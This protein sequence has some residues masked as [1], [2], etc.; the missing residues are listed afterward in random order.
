MVRILWAHVLLLPVFSVARGDGVAS[1]VAAVGVVAVPGVVA[2]LAGAGR[3][4]RSVAVVFGLLSASA[5]LVHAWD[6]QIEGHFH[7]FVMIAVLALYEDWVPFGLAIVYVVV[8]HGVLGA[9][10]PQSVYSHGGNPW[11]WAG[12]HGLF[13]LGSVAAGVVTWRLNED[14]RGRMIQASD[15]ACETAEQFRL[16]FESGTSGMALSAPDGRFMKV[17]RALC[18]MVGYS[19]AKMLQRGFQS[20]THPD[21]LLL[22][23]GQQRA[24]LDGTTEVYETEKRY[25]HCDGHEVWVRLGVSAVREKDGSVSYFIAQMVDVTERRRVEAELSHRALHDSLTH[26]PNRALFMDRLA[27]ALQRLRREPG[28]LGVLFVDLDRFKL[29]NDGMGHSAGDAILVAAAKRL[30][31]ATRAGDTVARFGGDEYTVLCEN[32]G[33]EEAS[34]VAQRII[35]AFQVPFEYEGREFNLSASIGVCVTGAPSPAPPDNL[36]RDADAAL[37]A[38]KEAGRGHHQLFDPQRQLASTDRLAVEHAI[39]LGLRRGEFVLH[40]QPE[41]ELTTQRIV[42]V[43]A[44]IRWQ[45]PDRG[46]LPPSEFIPIAEETDLIVPMGEWVLSEACSQLARWRA[47]GTADRSLQVAA[48]VSPRQLSDPGLPRAVSDAL[49]SARLEPE[50]LCLEITESA[51][52]HDTAIVR[53]N[54]RD[55]KDMGVRLAL[56]DFGVGFSS[57]SQIRELPPVDVIKLDR[58][59]TSG[60]GTNESDSAVVLAFLSLVRSLGLKGVAEGIETE[61]QLARLIEEGCDIG[62]GFHFARPQAARDIEQLLSDD[63]HVSAVAAVGGGD[64]A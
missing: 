6:G 48:N 20:I 43:E 22:D 41:V 44:L 57:L 38:A 31:E 62:Q 7:F 40:Y 16:A 58:S 56:D 52:V 2:T 25:L 8:Q 13:V 53:S 32:A 30:A 36:L 18:E 50:A 34:Q 64:G 39:R 59:F 45:H 3:R 9:V 24:M 5:V 10:S 26:L 4:A 42:A 54:F 14:M 28:E 61:A 11:L 29:V 47:S 49:A 33:A 60:L 15:W 19:E 37:Y 51:V 12:I 1:S 17:N 35:E 23:V 63:S 21:D 55:L 46:F 27:R